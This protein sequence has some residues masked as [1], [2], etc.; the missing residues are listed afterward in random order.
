MIILGVDPAL[1]ITGYGV[2]Q[3][4]GDS[5]VLHE[6]GIIQTRAKE[7]TSK[8]LDKIYRGIIKLIDDTHPHC[9][10]LE[11]IYSHYRH[12]TTSYILGQARGVICLAAANKDIPFA[13]YS[14]TRIKKAIV[15]KGLASKAQ[16][17]RMVANTLGLKTL[18]YYMDV[19]DALA[20]AIAHS[21][22]VKSRI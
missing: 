11:K 18:P 5:L 3:T 16:V 2:I 9:L 20:L 14:A 8:R 4:E 21:Y 22:I 19:T 17:Q 12:P 10:V 7:D 6:A 13:E 1:A 15:G